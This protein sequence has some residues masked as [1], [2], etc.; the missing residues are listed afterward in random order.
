MPTLNRLAILI[1]VATTG[2]FAF[3]QT[4]PP[5]A[6]PVPPAPPATAQTSA[7]QDDPFARI[8]R[9]IDNLFLSL[10]NK[11]GVGEEDR[12]II[13]ALRDKVAAY[14]HEHPDEVR[15]VAAELQL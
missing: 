9:S 8:Q 11:G 15:S 2:Q 10:Q 14:S 3:G 4:T 1:I 5:S 7:P 12:P 6:P 13:S